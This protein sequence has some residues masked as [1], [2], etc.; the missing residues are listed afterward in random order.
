MVNK[1]LKMVLRLPLINLLDNRSA[2]LEI[3][4]IQM[5]NSVLLKNTIIMKQLG[6]MVCTGICI[7]FSEF[8]FTHIYIYMLKKEAP[9]KWPNEYRTIHPTPKGPKK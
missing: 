4:W 2:Q 7:R 6:F 8:F 5:H 1:F 9:N 3:Q